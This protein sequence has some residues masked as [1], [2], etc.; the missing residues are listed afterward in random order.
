[1][2]NH[3][4]RTMDA[5]LLEGEALREHLRRIDAQYRPPP[6]ISRQAEVQ[7]EI[8]Y[9]RRR[10]RAGKRQIDLTYPLN[11]PYSFARVCFDPEAGEYR[12][13]V[14]EPTLRLGETDLIA[15]V[16]EK[17]EAMTD[18]GE[19]PVMEVGSLGD[20]DELVSYLWQKYE[21]ALDL[22]GIAVETTRKPVVFY[23]LQRDLVGLGRADPVMRDPFIEDVSC[24]G[25]GKPLYVF[26]RVFG[27]IMTDV[28][29]AEETE[30]NRTIMRLAQMSGRHI[31]IYQPILDATLT[32]GSRL[33]LT[34]GTEVTRKG[35]TFS[36]R[37]FSED[38]ISPI[39]L[40]RFGSLDAHQL[41]YF[42][43]CIQYKASILIS[44]GTA[45]GK[46]TLLNALSMFIRPEDKIVSIE[47]TPEINIGHQNWIQSV[48]RAGYGKGDKESRAGAISLFDLLVAALRQ[49]PEYLL[50]GEVRGREAMSLF[51]A[52]ST[53]HAAMATIHAANIQ[54]LLHRVENE[55][56]NIPRALMESLDV[57]AFP[58]QVLSQG[59][60]ARRVRM[61][62]EVVG[63]ENKTNNLLTNNVFEWDA[64]DDAFAFSGRSFVLEKIAKSTGAGR[65]GTLEEVE[66]K[67]EFLCLMETA[68]V[69]S[70]ADVTRA[71]QEY[72]LDSAQASEAMV[73]RAQRQKDLAAREQAARGGTPL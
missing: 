53:G 4:A 37:K 18:D 46:T 40:M 51:Q 2:H 8:S 66:R 14:Q 34:L 5:P 20:S 27:S 61:V 55:P 54:E 17:L 25:H 48:S 50:V 22:Y 39:D 32:D 68:D 15:R 35:S 45:S 63:L 72:Y 70:L 56:M 26:H 43:H 64:T 65:Q 57:V 69:S 9:M 19:F 49:R 23:F 58:G 41:A 36:I 21:K 62:T 73:K 11:P 13:L 24:N 60:R 38:P 30:L 33:N 44:G 47:D 10:I 29:F 3:M 6:S 28:A 71:V 12:Y 67:R 52:I 7:G 16:R 42:W 1:M 59:H 31:S